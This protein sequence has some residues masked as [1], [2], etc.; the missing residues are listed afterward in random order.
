MKTKPK[1]TPTCIY[2]DRAIFW[3]VRGEPRCTRHLLLDPWS[4]SPVGDSEPQTGSR[5]EG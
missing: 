1:L 3:R 4:P 2:C 5:G